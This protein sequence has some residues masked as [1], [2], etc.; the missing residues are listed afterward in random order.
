MS[1]SISRCRR[2]SRSSTGSAAEL[3]CSGICA[4]G[5]APSRN[6]SPRQVTLHDRHVPHVYASDV[7]CVAGDS[8]KLQP[9]IELKTAAAL[10]SRVAEIDCGGG[11]RPT[12]ALDDAENEVS[13]LARGEPQGPPSYHPRGCP[14]ASGQAATQEG[15]GRQGELRWG[16]RPHAR[17]DW[18]RTTIM[19]AD[20]RPAAA[21]AM[22]GTAD[23]TRHRR[24]SESDG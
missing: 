2:T 11:C 3:S 22:V 4:G 18:T 10:D 6:G 16:Q 7:I 12:I 17:S 15:G 13:R 23:P 5:T 19:V 20:R 1:T 9:I 21:G 8:E 14:S 24:R